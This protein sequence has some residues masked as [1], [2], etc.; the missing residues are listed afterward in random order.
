MDLR[1]RA[2]FTA[3]L[4]TCDWRRYWP[5]QVRWPGF[6]RQGQSRARRAGANLPKPDKIGNFRLSGKLR[7]AENIPR[8]GRM[9]AD[10]PTKF[11]GAGA[12]PYRLW[13]VSG[14]SEFVAV[15]A[16]AETCQEIRKV[17]R[18]QDWRYQITRDGKPI[19]EK[20]GFPLLLSPGQDLTSQG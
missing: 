15:V 2:S 6:E 1:V 4:S 5:R 9:A 13:H 20:T 8:G 3:V 7:G 17:R 12:K 14:R 11:E 16:E 18:R 19:D 10:E